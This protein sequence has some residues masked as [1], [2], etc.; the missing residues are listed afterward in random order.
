MS[1]WLDA[2]AALARTVTA[3]FPVDA[4]FYPTA[5]GGPIAITGSFGQ[6]P[7]LEPFAPEFG[8]TVVYFFVYLPD[9]SPQPKKGDGITINGA[10]YDIAEVPIVE[11]GG[12]TL[13]LRRN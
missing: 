5:G 10:T 2:D 6:P 7:M 1:T 11:G 12:S 4:S 9:I 13:Q 8:A 3:S